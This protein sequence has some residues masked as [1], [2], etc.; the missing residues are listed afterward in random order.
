MIASISRGNRTRGVLAYVYGPGDADEHTNQHTVAAFETLLPDP[1]RAPNPEHALTQLTKILDL[2]VN[3]AGKRAPKDHVW[4]CS[5]RAAPEDRHLSDTEWEQIARRVLHAAGIAPQGDPDG[6]RW[7][8]VRH[9]DDH[10]HIVATTVRADL[11]GARLHRDWHKVMAEL[12]NIE[13]D[14]GL[15]QVDRAPNGTRTARTTAKRATRAEF[16]KAKRQG[17]PE[18]SRQVLR[19]AVRESLAG[20]ISEDEFMSRLA[21]HG[22]RVKIRR[23]PSG[24]AQG[25]SFALPG[26]RNANNTP[27]WF[28]GSELGPDLTLPKI[29]A[30]LAVGAD[31]PSAT[32]HTAAGLQQAERILHATTV[33]NP[34]A[35]QAQAAGFGEVLDAFAQTHHGPGRAGLIAAAR[36]YGRI[37]H[38]H[39][40]AADQEMRALRTAAR[41]LFTGGPTLGRGEDSEAAALLLETLVFIAIALARHHNTSG[42]RQ[43]AR[44]AQAT[45]DH[46][47][48]AANRA[49]TAPLAALTAHGQRLSRPVRDQLADAVRRTL[50]DSTADRLLAAD[51][52][53]AL[54]ATLHQA[55]RHGPNPADLLRQAALSRELDSADDP[56]TVLAWRIR[57]LTDLPP[58]TPSR[59]RTT[60]VAPTPEPAPGSPAAGTPPRLR[61]R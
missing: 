42:H 11:T 43:Q 18:P 1:G 36:E 5:L 60:A 37:A 49:S 55:Q 26:D 44:A 38:T 61:G 8:A 3:Q 45:A 30:R 4:H 39:D 31:K 19:T 57:R 54:A 25:Y 56:A 24:D 23:L 13:Q 50:P 14:Y 47:R 22:V 15:R 16:H 21:A 34:I 27:V 9:A 7:V 35:A 40:R 53:P 10:I 48:T 46:L 58:A 6:C 51:G 29:R 12:T 41:T 2:R 28:P 59:P 17:R 52:W 20:A 32:V 33:D